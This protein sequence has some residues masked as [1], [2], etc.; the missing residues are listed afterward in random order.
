MLTAINGAGTAQIQ[1][2]SNPAV[3][4]FLSDGARFI[5]TCGSFI[6]EPLVGLTVVTVGIN[7][8]VTIPV[9]AIA[10]LEELPGSTVSVTNIGGTDGGDI[11]IDN[12]GTIS[13][14]GPGDPPVVVT[15][16]EP[17]NKSKKSKK[18]KKSGKSGKS[19]KSKKSGKSDKSKKSGKSDKSKKSGKSDKSKKSGKSDKSKKSGKSGKS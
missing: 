3:N 7:I 14:L 12:V 18:S 19:D 10:L 6:G 17:N 9:G 11:L 13:N 2:C 16:Q 1:T 5:A 15:V 8:R 4:I